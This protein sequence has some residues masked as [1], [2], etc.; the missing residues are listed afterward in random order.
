MA[1]WNDQWIDIVGKLIELTQE[2]ELVWE[3]G[4]ALHSIGGEREERIES[5]FTTTY[6]GKKLR[7]Y[8]RTYKTYRDRH[9]ITG[10]PLYDSYLA[11]EGVLEIVHDN[12]M[13]LWTFP[14]LD[15]TQ[16][17]LSSVQYRVAGVKEWI[18][19]ILVSQKPAPE[20]GEQEH[21][22][23]DLVPAHQ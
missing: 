5:V 21:H 20:I 8:K 15:I 11:S 6:K 19:E 12:G 7:L 14:K 17:L 16:H 18:A 2:G 1:K 13:T 4:A 10:V 22:R 3:V 23:A 9:K